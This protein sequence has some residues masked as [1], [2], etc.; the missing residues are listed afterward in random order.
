MTGP[1]IDRVEAAAYRI[2]TDQPE[3]D[4]TL[5][6]NATTM[7]VVHAEAGSQRGFGYSYGSAAAVSLIHQE[8]IKTLIGL[9]A[10]SVEGAWSAML[11]QVRNIG[12]SGVAASAISAIDV[13]LWDLKARLC[14]IPLVA[15][16]GEVR[17]A[18]PVYGSGGFTS[19]S[20]ERLCDQLEGWVA[21]GIPSVKMK[22]GSCPEQDPAR[23]RAARRAI[24]DAADLM[25]DANGAY[26]PAQA[27]TMAA[28][29]GEAGVSWF[30]EPVS[31]D[32]LEEMRAV[33]SGVPRGMAVAA[34]EY[35]WDWFDVRRLLESGAID[36]LQI[37]ATR[38]L[39]ITGFMG[40]ARLCQAYGMPLS[41]HTAPTLH[42]VLG[43]AATP[44]IHLEYFH[45]H[46]RIEEMLLEGFRVPERGALAPG[47]GAPGIGFALKSQE[48][49]RYAVA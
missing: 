1:A 12:R 46:A 43:A 45:D 28:V 25:V 41:T 16:L 21:Q 49:Q 2:P 11:R 5:S 3:A 42:A 38:C 44:V 27:I 35:A 13:A 24:G 33:R 9:P 15:L 31:S 34:G 23:V 17:R 37:D 20:V 7:V 4:G 14:G 39:G 6:W 22:V 18:T 48:A 32:H 19:Y 29:F 26:R 47:R 8:L 10:W 36:V 30:E 40:A